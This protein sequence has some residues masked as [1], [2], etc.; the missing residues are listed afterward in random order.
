MDGCPAGVDS[1]TC[2][3]WVF[4]SYSVQW[5]WP[6][7]LAGVCSI[8][9]SF[10]IA[11]LESSRHVQMSDAVRLACAWSIMCHNVYPGTG[12]LGA[13]LLPGWHVHTNKGAHTASC[14]C[15][16]CPYA[17]C[18]SACL[19]LEPCAPN[20][21]DQVTP[22]AGRQ[23]IMQACTWRTHAWLFGMASR[24][25]CIHPVILLWSCWLHLVRICSI[26]REIAL[27]DPCRCNHCS[28]SVCSWVIYSH[29]LFLLAPCSPLAVYCH[30]QDKFNNSP[31]TW[32]PSAAARMW[33][34]QLDDDA[35]MRIDSFD[36]SY[37]A[38]LWAGV[39]WFAECMYV[40]VC[41]QE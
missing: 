37:R 27:V 14:S 19:L 33:Q 15:K 30:Q 26:L 4:I 17:S 41:G 7:L 2:L 18:Q 29:G 34:H 5:V 20:Y 31:L 32:C 9:F 8:S 25:A 10:S 28:E 35:C 21:K 11:G 36:W 39:V 23:S 38:V 16:Y 22:T 12:A 40:D 13:S 6:I 1:L 3:S 24:E